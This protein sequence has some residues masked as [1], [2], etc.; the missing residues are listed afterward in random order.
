[1]SY[2]A[3]EKWDHKNESW[4]CWAQGKEKGS[5]AKVCGAKEAW[6]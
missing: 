4:V 1:M 5:M 2:S 6:L 3:C